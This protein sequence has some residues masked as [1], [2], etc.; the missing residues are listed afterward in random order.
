MEIKRGLA[1]AFMLATFLSLILAPLAIS[2]V[3]SYL[4]RILLVGVFFLPIVGLYYYSRADRANHFEA[5]IARFLA[6]LG[7]SIFIYLL[8]NVYHFQPIAELPPPLFAMTKAE[9]DVRPA[10][11]RN[12]HERAVF[13]KA[14]GGLHRRV[15]ER[16]LSVH[17]IDCLTQGLRCNERV[18]SHPKEVRWI[19]VGP[20]DRPDRL[21]QFKE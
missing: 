15:Q 8:Y 20:D 11:R 5:K 17:V 13:E 6:F 19:E 9:R 1:F 3:S 12:V 2:L 7:E 16:V 14:C 21:A 4:A 18:G 10:S